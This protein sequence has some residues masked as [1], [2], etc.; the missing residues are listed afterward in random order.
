MEKA[1]RILPHNL[2]VEQSLLGSLFLSQEAQSECF[3]KMQANDFY[4]AG[5]QKIFKAMYENYRGNNGVDYVTVAKTLDTKGELEDVGGIEYIA[6]LTNAVPSASNFK[7]YMEI[8]QN[9]ATMRRLIELCQAGINYCFDNTNSK[10]AL[11]YMEKQIFDLSREKDISE[12]V[13]ITEGVNEVID[14]MEKLSIDKNAFRGIKTGFPTLDNYTKGFHKGELIILAARPGIGKTALA[15]NMCTNAALYGGANVAIFSLEMHISEV[16]QRIMCSVGNIS[17]ESTKGGT[18]DS[19]VWETV[20]QTKEQLETVGLYVDHSSLNTPT[21]ILS[22]CRRLKAERG[23][24]M[25][26]IDYLQLMKSDTTKDSG[27]RQQEVADLTRSLKVAARELECP[28]IVLSQLSRDIEKRNDHKHQLSD[29]RES[30]SIEQDADIVLFIDRATETDKE[31][32]EGEIAETNTDDG[33]NCKLIIAKHRNGALGT[34]QLK[35]YGQYTRFEEPR[36]NRLSEAPVRNV[37]NDTE[38]LIPVANDDIDGSF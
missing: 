29:L 28:I 34:I 15:L 9:D 6:D 27:N 37:S 23:L 21:Q 25:V 17:S 24:D 14:R 19:K 4:S 12:L 26:M 31:I 38:E 2:E 20:M 22:K 33:D 36:A 32:V 7:N 16:A 3:A 30:G 18:T 8:V 10:Q 1:P 13:Q 35:W 11:Q 5:H